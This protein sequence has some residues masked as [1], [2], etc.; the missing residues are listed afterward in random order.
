MGEVSLE[1]FSWSTR[2][3]NL[4][5]ITH[6]VNRRNVTSLHTLGHVKFDKTKNIFLFTNSYR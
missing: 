6:Q 3:I 4:G 2:Q 5:S 1:V